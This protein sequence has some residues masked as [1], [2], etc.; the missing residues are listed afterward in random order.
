MKSSSPSSRRVPSP[1]LDERCFDSGLQ[2]GGS[3]K[4]GQGSP[5]PGTPIGGNNSEAKQLARLQAKL[6]AALRQLDVE[7]TRN[8]ALREQANLM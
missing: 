4:N 1:N 3:K 8:K 5:T 6:D 7:K 2:G